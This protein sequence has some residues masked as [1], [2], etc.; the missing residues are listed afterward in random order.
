MTSEENPHQQEALPSQEDGEAQTT[1]WLVI[2]IGNPGARYEKTRHNAGW[3]ALD[4]LIQRNGTTKPERKGPG[5]ISETDVSGYR[6]FL[7]RPTT[8][9]NRTGQAARYFLETLSIPP[10]KLIVIVD[11]V[12]LQ[13]GRLRV[14]RKG[15]DGGHNGLKSIINE[16]GTARFCRV[17]IGVGK[18]ISSKSQIEYVLQRPS[19]RAAR[20]IETAVER[21]AQAV[22]TIITEGIDVAMARFNTSPAAT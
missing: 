22:E 12:H 10:N 16:L 2:G 18:P 7:A 6:V 1:P 19:R 15:T 8:Y 14:R 11:D 3:D 5:F 9:V 21:A 13:T 17:R 4:A 20:A